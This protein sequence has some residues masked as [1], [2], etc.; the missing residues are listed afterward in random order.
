MPSYAYIDLDIDGLRPAYKRAVDFV[1]ATSIKYGLSHS[2]ISELGGR[3]K[4][5]IPELYDADYAWSARGP[6]AVDP[7]PCTRLV[8]ELFEV[9]S[10][11]AVENFRSLCTG[12]K[13]KS[14]SS[15]VALNYQ[16]SVIHRY[17]P[18][19]MIQGGDFTHGTGSGGESIYGKKFKDDSGGLKLKHDRRGILSMGNSGKNSNSSQFFITLGPAPACDKKHVVMGVMAHGGEVLDLIDAVLAGRVLQDEVPSV[20]IIITA[21]GTWTPGVDLTQGYWAADDTFRA[22]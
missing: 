14:K 5:S 22:F 10:P 4:I 20:P 11:L 8:F 3:E 15:G 12:S 16:G 13:G 21:C 6:C 7:Q 17:V 2:S 1:G 18:S 9:E 19:F